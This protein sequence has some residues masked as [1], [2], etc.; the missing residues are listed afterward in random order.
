VPRVGWH[1]EVEGRVRPRA[2]RAS[3]LFVES[4]LL[5]GDGEER[6]NGDLDER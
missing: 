4:E 2:P 5:G 1:R 6:E 3:I